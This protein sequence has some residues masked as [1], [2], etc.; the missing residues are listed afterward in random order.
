MVKEP[1][2]RLSDRFLDT[3]FVLKF[4]KNSILK[5][6]LFIMIN[7]CVNLYYMKLYKRVNN[8][9]TN[10]FI[11]IISVWSIFIWS[12]KYQTR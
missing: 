11:F 3:G 5:N 4:L 6:K 7:F 1:E 12:Q 10:M 2:L 9:I 8:K